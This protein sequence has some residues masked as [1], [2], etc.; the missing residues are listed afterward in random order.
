MKKIIIA[1][2]ST[3]LL[4]GIVGGTVWGVT[5]CNKKKDED[6]SIKNVQI[7]YLN[8][9]V[10]QGDLQ[11]FRIVVFSDVKLSAIT[12]KLNNGSEISTTVKTGESKEHEM[13]KAGSG[14]YYVDTQVET[15]ATSSLTLGKQMFEAFAYDE[16]GTR[17]ILSNEVTIFEVV[18]SSIPQVA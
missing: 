10:A 3:L 2:L 4:V 13:Y 15:I 14:K 16:E 12:Y 17:Y 11:T 1:I 6:T 18:A 7:M 8:D 5:S 9:E